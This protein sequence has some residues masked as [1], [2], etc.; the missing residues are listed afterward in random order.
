MSH[1]CQ[2]TYK[3]DTGDLSRGLLNGVEYGP[4]LTAHDCFELG[5]QA[6]NVGDHH[7]ANLWLRE[8]LRRAEEEEEEGGD[9]TVERADVLEYM[10]FSAYIQGNMRRALRL[11]E[12]L[13][14]LEPDH[15]RAAGNKV[16]Y[17][18]SLKEEGGRVKKKGEWGE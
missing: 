14:S 11:T 2:D 18:S 7:H 16:Y 12:D 9:R 1:F 10:A 17:E 6:Y 13:L 15:P 5:R 3:L 4:E 8:A